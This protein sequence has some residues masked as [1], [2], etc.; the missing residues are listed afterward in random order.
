M[1]DRIWYIWQNSKVGAKNK[2]FEQL[3]NAPLAPFNVTIGDV[4][5]TRNLG[6]EYAGDKTNVTVKATGGKLKI[7]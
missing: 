4:L 1:I 7:V 3:I 6:Y 2:G 5:D